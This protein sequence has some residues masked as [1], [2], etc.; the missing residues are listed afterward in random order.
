M[1]Q[2]YEDCEQKYTPQY[3]Q[4]DAARLVGNFLNPAGR[5]VR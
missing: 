5:L 4:I 1:I 2:I 3:N